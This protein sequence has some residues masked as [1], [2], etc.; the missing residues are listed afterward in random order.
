MSLLEVSEMSSVINSISMKLSFSTYRWLWLTLQMKT[1]YVNESRAAQIHCGTPSTTLHRLSWCVANASS[2]RVSCPPE[3][4]FRIASSLN[5]HGLSD[6][7]ACSG[8]VNSSGDNVWLSCVKVSECLRDVLDDA[9]GEV[10]L[11]NMHLHVTPGKLC[12]CMTRICCNVP[13]RN[14]DA[15]NY[16]NANTGSAVVI[17]AWSDHRPIK[18]IGTC[19]CPIANWWRR[20]T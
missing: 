10:M 15:Y 17:F 3:I 8:L 1:I 6:G 19:Y 13:P 7:W 2:V 12:T 14:I 4:V 16:S 20:Y 5:L 9:M 11:P 18:K